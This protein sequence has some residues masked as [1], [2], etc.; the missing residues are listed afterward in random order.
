MY[1]DNQGGGG[2]GG[3]EDQGNPQVSDRSVHTVILHFYW[4]QKM[5]NLQ[6]G[7]EKGNCV[8]FKTMYTLTRI[9]S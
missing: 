6:I 7:R 9:R 2:G 3:C 8:K 1:L 4:A 5:Q